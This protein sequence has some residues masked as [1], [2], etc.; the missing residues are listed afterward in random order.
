[1]ADSLKFGTSGL[2]GLA[3]D[4]IGPP[5]ARYAAAYLAY[6]VGSGRLAPGA[7]ILVGR[8]L[9][10]SSPAIA[11]SVISAIAGAGFRAAD[12]GELATPALA[13]AA[14]S[15]GAP[16]IMVTGSHIPADRN[17]LKFYLAA[18][19]ITKDDEAG[20]LAALPEM[21]PIGAAAAV[22]M[23][24]AR[25]A[26][27][28][29]YC[30]AFG[31]GLLAGARI[32]VF[33]H[34]SVLR[35]D[36]AALLGDLGAEV[37]ALGRADHFIPID[38]EAVS[39]E[40]AA[41][42]AQWVQS[43]RLDALVSTDGDA[44]R[45]LVADETGAVLR[46]DLLGILTAQFLDADAV[47]TPV[48]SNSAIE[49][50]GFARVLRTRVGSPHV[51]AGMAEAAASGA[52]AVVGF[53]A[54]GGT[55]L[56]SDVTV[57]EGRLGALPTRDAVL[58]I[59]SVLALAR[60]RGLTLSGLVGTLPARI[61]RSDR[62]EHVPQARSALLLGQ[63]AEPDFARGYF[64]PIGEVRSVSDIDGLRFGLASGEVVHYRASG[65]APELRCYT[66]AETAGRADELLAW[67]LAA[68]EGIVRG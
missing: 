29:R 32:G 1:M 38:T 9:R 27:L 7:E 45:P 16:A 35:D 43:E 22:P 12:C 21:A 56:G 64:A 34:S 68:A 4:L 2:R 25:Q 54:N 14:Q 17:G 11:A 67:G 8:D 51:I 23:P 31:A 19:E 58:P 60:R 3:I 61:A 13:L 49:G 39:A 6:L 37:V 53:E 24:V 30:E 50:L 59:L 48:T 36:L 40:T 44:D 66:E 63:L 41:Q 55:L 26:Y 46:G 47:V 52:R 18:G 15:A 10:D 42:A 57:G 20:I 33:Q 62:L 65:N 5:S 28:A